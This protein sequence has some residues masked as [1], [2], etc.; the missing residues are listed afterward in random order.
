[1]PWMPLICPCG[2]RLTCVCTESGCILYA[3][4]FFFL[5]INRQS[6]RPAPSRAM[7]WLHDQRRGSCIALHGRPHAC[8]RFMRF[9]GIMGHR[10]RRARAGRALRRQAETSIDQV[11]KAAEMGYPYHNR[12]RPTYCGMLAS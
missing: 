5:K 1:M 11:V 12:G 4:D 3:C 2:S 6:G 7:A 10:S 8:V 9:F